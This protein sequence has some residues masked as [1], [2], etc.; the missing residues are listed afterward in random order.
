MTGKVGHTRSSLAAKAPMPTD[1]TDCP[2]DT[3]DWGAEIEALPRERVLE[4]VCVACGCTVRGVEDRH[5][6]VR[7]VEEVPI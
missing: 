3:V 2:H 6:C 5:G 7:G 4:G 1:D